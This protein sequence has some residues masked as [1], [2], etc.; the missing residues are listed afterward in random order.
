MTESAHPALRARW[1]WR[2]FGYVFLC[3]GCG[4]EVVGAFTVNGAN[5]KLQPIDRT[6]EAVSR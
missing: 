6:C 2:T 1:F 4:Q 5:R 3:H